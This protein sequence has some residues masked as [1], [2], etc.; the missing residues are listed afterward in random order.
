MLAPGA[1]SWL[2][3]P[4]ARRPPALP[5]SFQILHPSWGRPF[6]TIYHLRLLSLVKFAR[7]DLACLL[8]FG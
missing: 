6:I 5:L 7:L 8:D 4:W 2:L 1:R 3:W